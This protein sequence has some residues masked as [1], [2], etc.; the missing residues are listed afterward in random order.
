M[1]HVTAVTSSVIPFTEYCWVYYLKQNASPRSIAQRRTSKSVKFGQ[2]ATG[3]VI[4]NFWQ[5]DCQ[6]LPSP[7]EFD[8]HRTFVWGEL[9]QCLPKE[10][11]V[12]LLLSASG[13][14][15]NGLEK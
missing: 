4:E 5:T 14:F 2:R 3:A 12:R 15:R 1:L 10:L 13:V 9:A 11:Y 7:S 8:E 6:G